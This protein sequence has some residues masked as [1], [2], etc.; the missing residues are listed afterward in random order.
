MT[1]VL[2]CRQP[3]CIITPQLEL[4]KRKKQKVNVSVYFNHQY[5][6]IV[7][8]FQIVKMLVVLI[9]IFGV[10]WLPYHVYFLYSYHFPEIRSLPYIQHVFLGFYWCAMAHS[11]VNPIVYYFMNPKQVITQTTVFENQVK[12][13]IQYCE[14][15][16]LHFE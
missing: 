5:F 13:R 10:C 2:W 11:M 15:S 8:Y 1:T 4:A 3:L 16:E 7:M 6:I 14:R 12:S 9:V